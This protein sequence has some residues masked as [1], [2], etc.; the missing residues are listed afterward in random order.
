M[1]RTRTQGVYKRPDSKNYWIA[2]QNLAGKTIR[3]SSGTTNFKEAQAILTKNRQ[4]LMEGKNPEIKKIKNYTF[5]ELAEKYL[6][7]CERQKAFKTKARKIKQLVDTFG[8]LPL[9][10]FN[11][12]QIEQFQTERLKF[13]KPATVNRLLATLKH[14]FTKAEEWEMVEEEVLK[15]TR[16][17]KLLQENNRRLRFLSAIETQELIKACD[18]HLKPI[19]IAALNTGMRKN[20]I[21]TLKWEQNIDLRHNF[22]L[23]D[24][25]KNGERREIP[26]NEAF[27]K[28]LKSQIRRIDVPYVFFNPKTGKRYGDV[29]KSFYSACRR[30]GIKDFRFHDLRHTFASHLVMAGV[31]ITTVKELMG[32]KTLSMTLRYAHLAPSHKVAAVDLLNH[33]L[34]EKSTSRLVHV[35]QAQI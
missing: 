24:T 35:S 29:K 28:V 2:Y 1:A 31:D 15:K 14:M 25:T 18:P 6:P 23:L 33:A 3:K 17:V 9:R 8:P 30:A 22:I 12:L 21:L 26:I 5:S 20:E 4:M 34:S 16:K 19:V 13:N 7:W 32:H 10:Q 11:T 27:L